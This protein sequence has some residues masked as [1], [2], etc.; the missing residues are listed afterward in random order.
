M[1]PQLKVDWCD[2]RASKYAVTHW[3]YSRSMPSGKCVNFGVWENGTFIGAVMYG[4][5]AAPQAAD[6]FGLDRLEVCELVRVALNRHQSPVTRIV[7]VTLRLLRRKCPGI[8]LVVSYADP[9]QGHAG[10]IYQAGNWIYLGKTAPCEHF[11]VN[12][13]G[14]R[15]H[16]KT[17]RTG[18]R[19]YATQLLKDGV[20]S[21]IKVW[22]HKYVFP[23]DQ[24]LRPQ[25]ERQ[26][27]PHP[28]VESVD[29]DTS[30]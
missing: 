13:S 4:T 2:Y 9:E 6:P 20:L 8:R 30:G 14:R 10:A 27:K 29:S 19:G 25:L 24:T 21:S 22:K 1:K 7:A 26:R 17:V 11:V 18:R 5:G 3:H 28:R 12:K 15:I 16:S 23:I